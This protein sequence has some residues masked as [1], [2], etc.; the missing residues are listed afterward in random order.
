M[1]FFK[2]GLLNEEVFHLFF[3]LDFYVFIL[4]LNIV[5]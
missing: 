1:F 2:R 5:R 4:R 3:D